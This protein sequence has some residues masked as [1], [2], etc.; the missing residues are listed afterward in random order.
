MNGIP[1]IEFL[2]I[3]N[4]NLI[5]IRD[6]LSYNIGHINNAINIP[7]Y[8]L[9]NN[10]SH[11]LNKKMFYYLYCDYGKQSLEISNRLNGFGYHTSS[12]SGGYEEYKKYVNYL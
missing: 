3:R 12:L 4:P 2:K 11:Y 6:N 9:L 8:N 5:D 1:I 10:H 7:Y